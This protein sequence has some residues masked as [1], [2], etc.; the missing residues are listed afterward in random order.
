M[1]DEYKR[2]DFEEET[3]SVLEN[4]AIEAIQNKMHREETFLNK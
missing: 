4:K 1:L 2:W 3:I